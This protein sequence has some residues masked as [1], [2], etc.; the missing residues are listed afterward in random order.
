MMNTL[1]R[2]EDILGEIA[3]SVSGLGGVWNSRYIARCTSPAPAGTKPRLMVV[4]WRELGPTM[5]PNMGY[6]PILDQSLLA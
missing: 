1:E 3:V 6:C 4:F 2:P 5:D